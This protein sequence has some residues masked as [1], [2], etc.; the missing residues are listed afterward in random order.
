M[1]IGKLIDFLRGTQF[2]SALSQLGAS[3][4]QKKESAL[5]VEFENGGLHCSEVVH[6]QTTFVRCDPN[7]HP[8]EEKTV[9]M[10]IHNHPLYPSNRLDEFFSDMDFRG[11]CLPEISGL[12]ILPAF[13]APL[14][15]LLAQ[16]LDFSFEE[17]KT[18]YSSNEEIYNAAFKAF[19]MGARGTPDEWIQSAVDGL[20]SVELI[21]GA[22]IY[23]FD[24]SG[25]VKMIRTVGNIEAFNF[26]EEYFTAILDE[27]EYLLDLNEQL[28]QE[29][30]EEV[31]G[32]DEDIFKLIGFLQSPV[33]KFVSR[34]N[35][36][37]TGVPFEVV[38]KLAD[39]IMDI[40][41]DWGQRDEDALFI[42]S[43][44]EVILDISDDL[45]SEMIER[46]VWK[47]FATIPFETDVYHFFLKP[48][49]YVNPDLV[50]IEKK[51]SW[52]VDEVAVL[53][54]MY[55][56]APLID[57]GISK[58]WQLCQKTRDEL[59]NLPGLG[60]TE[61]CF[62]EKD[63]KILGLSLNMHLVFKNRE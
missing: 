27:E 30:L 35:E 14:Y 25:N 6:G 61:V 29:H 3:A 58:M 42:P 45:L 22:A 23:L 19:I 31:N 32:T 51:L 52:N 13:D 20:T 46:G 50:S 41:P 1:T 2:C 56:V 5:N 62:I 9:A 39:V 49:P 44:I 12:V 21:A 40:K 33:G 34:I 17:L 43:D 26:S 36:L 54:W 10:H 28:G 60:E 11:L 16:K 37:V 63:I 4:L 18:S 57:A 47:P 53:D 48:P 55:V 7:S 24:S 8:W 38:R 59:L 15:L